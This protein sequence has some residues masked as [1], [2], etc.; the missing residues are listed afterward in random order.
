MSPAKKKK[1]NSLHAL[2]RLPRDFDGVDE[3]ELGLV[4]VD[5]AVQRRALAPLRHDGKDLLGGHAP[6]EEQHVDVS[7]K[8]GKVSLHASWHIPLS[9]LSLSN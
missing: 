5:V 1:N 6:H 7:A 8:V 4:D 2:R 9:F 3:L